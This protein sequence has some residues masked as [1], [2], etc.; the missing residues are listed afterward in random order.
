[1]VMGKICP[2]GLNDEG[3]VQTPHVPTDEEMKSCDYARRAG[4]SCLRRNPWTKEIAD[5]ITCWN[6]FLSPTK[7]LGDRLFVKAESG[8]P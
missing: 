3:G 4:T 6:C 8:V 1:M 5:W 2:P 7:N